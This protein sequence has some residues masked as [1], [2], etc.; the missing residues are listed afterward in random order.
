MPK[1]A[2]F[3]L[4]L[5]AALAGCGNTTIIYDTLSPSATQSLDSGQ[6]VTV[7]ATVFNDPSNSGVTWSLNGAGTLTSVTSTSVVY[8]APSGVSAAA[9]TSIVATPVKNTLYA[10]AVEILLEPAPVIT[11]LTLPN[12][13]INISYSTQLSAS[14]GTIPFTW[15]IASGTLPAGLSLSSAGVI[16]GTPTTVG[17]STFIV[18]ATDA[19]TIP[20]SSS[21]TLTLV[22]NAPT[23][24]I[25]A[26]SLANEVVGKTYST[27][28]TL[29][30]GVAPYTWSVA[31]GGGTLPTGVTL[32]AAGVLSGTPASSGFYSFTAEVTDTEPSPQV[33]TKVLTFTVYN[34]LAITTT[35]LPGGSLHNV[36]ATTTLQFTGGTTP[37][38]WS[39]ASGSLPA[40]LSLSTAGVIS[41]TPTATGTSTFTVQ[42][43]D[44]SIPQQVVTATYSITIVLSTLAITT[45]SLPQ[46]TVGTAYSASLLYSG[47][48]PPVTWA[49]AGGSGPLPANLAISS[50][51]VISGTPTTAGT[52]PITVQATDTTPAS[53]TQ[54]LSIT[55]VALAP[56]T[57]STTTVPAGNIGTAY[58]TTFVATGGAVPYT[59]SIASGTLPQGL[60]LAGST[61]V[62]SG[63]P[64]NAGSFVFTVQVK[65]SEATPVT[66]S[67]QFTLTIGT[68]LT[69]GTNNSQ[70]SGPY[71]FLV[72]GFGFG[73]NSGAVYGFAELGS[74]SANGA[75]ALTGTA[76]INV[77][78]GVQTAVAVTGSYT[79]GS[80]GRGLMVL[81]SGSNT[82]IYSIAAGP[83][84]SGIAQSLSI[85]EFDNSNG[86]SG[87]NNASG[88][89]KL[90][91]SSA[92]AASTINGTFA[93]GL[94]GESPCSTCVA[95]APLYGPVV[96]VG[97]FTANG[98]STISSGQQDAAA[99][100]VN[101]TGVTLTGSFTAPSTTTG[102]GALHFVNA[103]TLFSAA[104]TDFYYAIVSSSEMLLL[105]S[106]SHATN[107][108]L[109]GDV[110]LQKQ[111][112]YTATSLT[113]SIIGYESQP[114]GGN[115]STSYPAALNA[116]LDD[117]TITG[118][119]TATLA[120]DANRAG[121]FSS[122][123][124]SPTSITYTTATTGRTAVTT[125]STNQV[126]YLYNTDT[127][128]ALD[129]AGTAAYPGL[130]QYQQQV[131]VAPYPVLL[132][133]SYGAG[134]VSSPVPATDV[135][136]I[137][138]FALNRGGVDGA[139]SGDLTTT[140]DSSSPTG[141]LSYDVSTPFLY[142]EGATGRHIVTTSGSTVTQTVLY[143][144]NS[145][146]AVAIPAGTTTTP[147]VT[148]LQLY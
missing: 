58:S 102:V 139:I 148:L 12:G 126:L 14:G 2:R 8:T 27:Q 111:T 118:S 136:G 130:I 48:N 54:A 110:Q 99:Y 100:G 109:S 88:I 135:T 140:I 46:G 52:Y 112:S 119:G 101:Y 94:S 91:T 68:T 141:A 92:F 18:K 95:P 97:L 89:A 40:G 124:A 31:S 3:S 64:L 25:T 81:T 78:T 47:G 143:G 86:A 137:Y 138:L 23:L 69:V 22:V 71:A 30:G 24:K 62:L 128:F 17:T 131:V 122:T 63:T 13:T 51:G 87:S 37:V 85:A 7:T 67:R 106:D 10:A 4:L 1:F 117:L 74:L 145:G 56:L 16:S 103:G 79:L 26:T 108:L 116:I 21:Q 61:G 77:P 44:S 9:A 120:Q 82:N 96:A 105:S 127:G 107:A 50:A 32:S 29:T 142:A 146:V 75:G 28:L 98:V 115:G 59:W 83:L 36:Y 49:L 114:N 72:N 121:T 129:Q 15:S 45:T 132:S 84:S 147:T 11:T 34:A 53:V 66:T 33:A 60:S 113:G 123:A 39:L 65:D 20:L 76:Y 90:Q 38:T 70:L 134:T 80:D 35:S 125:G 144:I 73:S 55:I 6:S 57:I 41:G 133:G 5:L 104:P 42:L 43:A 19:A 93:F